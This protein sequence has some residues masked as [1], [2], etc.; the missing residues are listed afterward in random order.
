MKY[1]FHF[2]KTDTV[3]VAISDTIKVYSRYLEMLRYDSPFYMHCVTVITDIILTIQTYLLTIFNTGH[4]EY[5]PTAVK[6][7]NIKY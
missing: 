2:S 5:I 1:F 3:L 4:F 7:G 6:H